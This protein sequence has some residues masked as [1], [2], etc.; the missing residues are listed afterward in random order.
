MVRSLCTSACACP[1]ACASVYDMCRNV[2]GFGVS[3]VR[4]RLSVSQVRGHSSRL[5][6][7]GNELK[8]APGSSSTGGAPTVL[9]LP[10]LQTWVCCLRRSGARSASV[11]CVCNA[12]RWDVRTVAARGG[13]QVVRFDLNGFSTGCSSAKPGTLEAV[14]SGAPPAPVGIATRVARAVVRASYTS[15][16]L[17]AVHDVQGALTRARTRRLST[18]S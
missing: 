4:V 1:C 6:T 3:G 17:S 2:K 13:A 7:S 11:Y 15:T 9:P 16:L 18:C 10:L 8:A 14:F 12:M 5:P